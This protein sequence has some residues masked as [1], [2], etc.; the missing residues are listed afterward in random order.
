[1]KRITRK[2]LRGLY[3]PAPQSLYDGIHEALADLPEGKGKKK[4]KKKISTGFILAAALLV[5]SAVGFAATRLNLFSD[6]T[7]YAE[8]HRAAGGRGG[9]GGE[10]LGHAGER[11][12]DRHCGR[13]RVRRPGRHGVGEDYTEGAGEVRAVQRLV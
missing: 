11:M 9:A 13:G 12:G 6:M 5:L 10:D 4:V 7:R 8:S 3:E 2:D 1:M